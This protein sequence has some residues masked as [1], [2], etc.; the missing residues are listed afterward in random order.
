MKRPCPK[1]WHIPEFVAVIL[2]LGIHLHSSTFPRSSIWKQNRTR[3]KSVSASSKSNVQSLFL[4]P[5]SNSVLQPSY[6]EFYNRKRKFGR[7]A[8]TTK[9]VLSTTTAIEKLRRARY[10]E[11]K[12]AERAH[13]KA[14][15]QLQ[16]P[17][18]LAYKMV[19]ILSDTI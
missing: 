10:A 19:H 12:R 5:I 6:H 14:Q 15:Q 13:A 3:K 2:K 17:T 7:P 9:P 16:V 8:Q 11:L 1:T 18:W 4:T